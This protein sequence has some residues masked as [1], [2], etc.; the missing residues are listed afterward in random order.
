MTPLFSETDARGYVLRPMLYIN[1]RDLTF[2]DEPDSVHKAVIDIL[3]TTYG[4]HGNVV[5][6]LDKTYAIRLKDA[7]Y[8][9]VLE[10]G[11]LYAMDVP[12]KKPGAYQFRTAV[13]DSESGKVGSASQFLRIP[14][15][16]KGRLALSSIVLQAEQADA[17]GYGSAAVRKFQSGQAV[18]YGLQI[19]N[20]RLDPSTKLPKILTQLRLYRDGV[21]MHAG[22]VT[23]FKAEGSPDLKRISAAFQTRIPPDLNAGSYVLQLVLTDELAKEKV[24]TAAQW[25]DFEIVKR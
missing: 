17:E 18:V 3:A 23:K 16:S 15:V 19:F 9:Q 25:I 14:D 6:T 12:L 7:E 8:K 1:A 21:L 11:F 4:D 10:K 13:R 2:S 20:A 24:S 22:P 5:D